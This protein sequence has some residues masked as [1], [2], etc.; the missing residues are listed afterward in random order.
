MNYP[1]YTFCSIYSLC[2][3]KIKINIY[4]NGIIYNSKAEKV[5]QAF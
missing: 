2:H 3:L 1:F 5:H 4:H